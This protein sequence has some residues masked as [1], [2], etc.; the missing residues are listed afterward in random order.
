MGIMEDISTVD[1]IESVVNVTEHRDR[2]LLEATLTSTLFE[3]LGASRVSFYKVYSSHGNL[4]LKE[5]VR[6]DQQGIHQELNASEVLGNRIVLD[7][8]SVYDNCIRQGEALICPFPEAR[9]GRL[10]YPVKL[11]SSTVGI[12]DIEAELPQEIELKLISGFMKIY[13]NYLQLLEESEH[14]KLTGLLNR[15]A[16]DK[17]LDK[18]LLGK[19]AASVQEQAVERRKSDDQEELWLAVVDIDLFKQINDQ[20]G[21]LYGDEVL[22]ILSDIM[23]RSFRMSDKLFRFGGEEFV[24]LLGRTNFANAYKV[25]NR[26]RQAVEDYDFPRVGKVTVCVGFVQIRKL[27]IPSIVVGHADLALYYAKEHGRNQ[28]CSY[29]KLVAEGMLDQV[30]YAFDAEY[31]CPTDSCPLGTH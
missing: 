20:H 23:C 16:F 5:S 1:I 6:A 17:N 13:R 9:H 21:H 12:L 11:H 15:G 26:F 10:L 3:L 29:E 8:S 27:D 31:L 18:M 4:C 24:L 22:V 7:G 14:D 2:D 30:A 25:L 19:S 28:V